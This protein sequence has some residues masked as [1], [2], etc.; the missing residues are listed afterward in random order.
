MSWIAL[1]ARAYR[2]ALENDAQMAHVRTARR[3]AS[4]RQGEAQAWLS[5]ARHGDVAAMQEML[6]H[7]PQVSTRILG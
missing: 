4:E 2:S 6:R 5:A 1:S 3:V 7:S